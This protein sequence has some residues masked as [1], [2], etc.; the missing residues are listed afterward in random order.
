MRVGEITWRERVARV[1][2]RAY[3]KEL[4]LSKGGEYKNEIYKGQSQGKNPG[5]QNRESYKKSYYSIE[6]KEI[7]YLILDL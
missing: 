4:R 6:S 1:E 5:H 2:N 7:A 3:D